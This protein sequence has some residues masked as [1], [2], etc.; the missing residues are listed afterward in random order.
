[1]LIAIER[2]KTRFARLEGRLAGHPELKNVL[3]IHDDAIRWVTHRIPESSL[4][5]I[6]LLYP[7]PYPKRR[8]QNKRW[9][10]R[11][12]MGWLLRC[13]EPN[14]TLTLATNDPSYAQEARE[15]MVDLWGMQLIDDQSFSADQ[16]APSAARTHFE[17]K[18]LK[19]GQICIELVFQ[20]SAEPAR[21]LAG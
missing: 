18:Y 12:F 20:R 2:T 8:Q 4:E 16:L 3:A 5:R 17:K 6:F 21:T 14:G 15:G 13:L 1:V 11:P 9:H 7:N 19:R 10:N